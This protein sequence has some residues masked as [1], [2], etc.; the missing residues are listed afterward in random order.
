MSMTP[1]KQASPKADKIREHRE[2]S[3]SNSKKN[4]NIKQVEKL[5]QDKKNKIK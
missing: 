1:K 5:K 2:Q 4:P 3:V